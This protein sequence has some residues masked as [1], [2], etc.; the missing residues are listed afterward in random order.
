MTMSRHDERPPLLAIRDLFASY[1]GEVDVL[2]GVSL[3]VR[4]GEMVTVVGPNGAGKSTVLKAV[5]GGLRPRSGQVRLDGEDITGLSGHRVT[6]K[7]LAYV[8]QR[9]NVFPRL[10]VQE[11]LELGVGRR[12][13]AAERRTALDNVFALFPRLAE[14][15]RQPAGT[16]SGGERQM[17]AIARALMAGPRMLLLDEP[18]A[19]LSPILVASVFERIAEIRRAGVTILLVEQNARRALAMSDRGYV[20]ELG[21]TRFEGTGPELLD[22]PQVVDLYLGATSGRSAELRR[23]SDRTPR[24]AA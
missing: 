22:D 14:R 13:N 18:S 15:R 6:R 10:T 16:L 9:D 11:N 12:L 8:P 19:G 20:L 7:K 21:Q 4:H 1:T 2:R 23:A 5:I 17:A 24:G 3:D